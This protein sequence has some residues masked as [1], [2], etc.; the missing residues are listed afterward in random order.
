VD[1]QVFFSIQDF[2]DAVGRPLGT[3]DW[4]VVDQNRID[5][6]AEATGDRQWIH[7]DPERAASGPYGKTVAHG[8]LTAS[9]MPLLV[10]QIYRVEG[11]RMAVNYGL[12]RL[13]FVTPVVVDSEV[14]ASSRLKEVLEIAGGVQATLETTI[15]LKGAP[16]PACVA[17]TVARIY[18]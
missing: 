15:E 8:Y 7:V 3:S 9:L 11:A 5:L 10:Q 18:F 1:V 12:N 16:K 14:R 4:L 6:F 17:E 13:R 2:V